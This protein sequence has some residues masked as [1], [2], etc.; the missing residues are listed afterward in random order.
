MNI[1]GKIDSR[2]LI[3]LWQV[4][5]CVLLAGLFLYNPFL[6]VG[7][8]SGGLTVCHPASY[9]ATLA[10]SEVEQF[11]QP[12]SPST[13][14]LPNVSD[15]QVLLPQLALTHSA[16]RHYVEEDL[17]VRPQTGFSSSLWFRPPPA[18]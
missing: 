14:P 13:A 18:I 6:A 11:A 9:R 2:N 15:V 17:I 8:N 7:T 16:P 10:S 12:N 5:A 1:S 4:F 3:P